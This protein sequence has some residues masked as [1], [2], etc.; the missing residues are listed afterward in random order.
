[1]I[2]VITIFCETLDL[3]VDTTYFFD[4]YFESKFNRQSLLHLKRITKKVASLLNLVTID[5]I[6]LFHKNDEF[7]YQKKFKK[8]MLLLPFANF[9]FKIYLQIPSDTF[10]LTNDAQN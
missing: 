6:F 8:W 10:N 4:P 3:I 9:K 2:T 5:K 7:I 1:M